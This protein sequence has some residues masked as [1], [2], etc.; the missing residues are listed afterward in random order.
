MVRRR[1]KGQKVSF[2]IAT[3][4]LIVSHTVTDLSPLL[5]DSELWWGKGR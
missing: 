2:A 3:V 5:L 4:S 1:R